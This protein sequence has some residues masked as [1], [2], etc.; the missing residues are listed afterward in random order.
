M[1]YNRGI[2]ENATPLDR[3]ERILAEDAYGNRNGNGGCGCGGE[4]T[5]V[6]SSRTGS[7]AD[8][9]HRDILDKDVPLAMSYVPMQEWQKLYSEEEGFCRGTIFKE[10]DFPF[11]GCRTGG[12]RR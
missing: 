12:C 9:V 7:A 8:C 4:D 11:V 6:G 10:L 5:A 2:N 3:A 1:N